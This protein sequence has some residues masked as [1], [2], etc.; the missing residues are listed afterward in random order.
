MKSWFIWVGIGFLFCL[1]ILIWQFNIPPP[2]KVIQNVETVATISADSTYDEC[3]P[4]VGGNVGPLIPSQT[5][6]IIPTITPFPLDL[7]KIKKIPE[8][9]LTRRAGFGISSPTDPQYWAA[10]LGSN[11]YLDWTVHAKSST[12]L[13]IH[14]K[15]IRVHAGCISPSLAEVRSEVANSPGQVWIIGN[16]PDVIWQDNVPAARYSQ[17]YHDLYQVI[18]TTDPSALVAIAGVS[19]AT[20]LR[21]KYLDQVLL[22]YRNQFGGL[23]PVD[24]WTVH[25]Y[26][27]REERNSWGVDIPPGMDET[28]G[29]LYEV[30]D[31]ARLDLFQNQLIV[32]RRWMAAKG[33]QNKPLAVTE[34]GILM[35]ADYGFPPELVADYLEATFSWLYKAKDEAIGYPGDAFRLVQ[36]WAWFSLSDPIYSDANL[37]DLSNG[38]LTPLGK[39]FRTILEQGIGDQP[40]PG[41]CP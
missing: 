16:E 32:F 37:G 36:K 34:F 10:L 25:A 41:G 31:H 19:Q 26:T 23:M 18:K 5:S 20:P 33:Y 39:R 1:V 27:L 3:D 12:D 15:M 17:A 35:P 24:W 4:S 8:S 14:W 22:D 38:E 28:H 30:E 40:F 2:T 13:P 21:L 11:W 9:D 29:E 6:T 7:S